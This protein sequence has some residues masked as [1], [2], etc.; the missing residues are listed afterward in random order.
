MMAHPLCAAG[1]AIGLG[2]VILRR[3]SKGSGRFQDSQQSKLSRLLG[4]QQA[5]LPFVLAAAIGLAGCN[6]KELTRSRAASLIEKNVNFK[7][8]PIV[9]QLGVGEVV[10]KQ[11]SLDEI[12]AD[13]QI[14][15]YYRALKKQEVEDF[16]LTGNMLSAKLT[17]KGMRFVTFGSP[18]QHGMG[19]VTI[20][21]CDI[22]FDSVTG[23]SMP[24][25][26]QATVEYVWKFVNKTPFEVAS[27]EAFGVDKGPCGKNADNK[28]AVVLK[29]YDDGWRYDSLMPL[30]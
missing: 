17:E 13:P 3:S 9:S 6:S 27:E 14:G 1:C 11:T 2:W 18:P 8:N 10:V 19:S 15:K 21:L 12:F 30:R 23:I 4:M 29:L 7:G 24:S 22:A 26:D 25:P 5:A 20:R 16:T 28:G